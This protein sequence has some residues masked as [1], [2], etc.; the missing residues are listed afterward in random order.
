MCRAK[1]HLPSLARMGIRYNIYFSYIFKNTKANRPPH[2][3]HAQIAQIGIFVIKHRDCFQSSGGGGDSAGG[4]I[5]ASRQRE[6]KAGQ[7]RRSH[8]G[9]RPTS[10]PCRDRVSSRWGGSV[11]AGTDY[12]FAR[13]GAFGRSWSAALDTLVP[14][15]G[16]RPCL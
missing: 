2:S 8:G 9:S 10:K 14:A 12:I 15:G 4:E 16:Q 13:Q 11:R 5:Y 1:K 7:D 3:Q 6:A